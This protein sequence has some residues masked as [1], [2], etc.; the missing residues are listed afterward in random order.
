M[1][2]TIKHHKIGTEISGKEFNETYPDIELIKLTN[3]EEN[4]NGFQFKDGLNID[5][6]D[7]YPKQECS[8]GGIYFI[9]KQFAYRW[10]YY[11]TN[12]HY[13][14]IEEEN[15]MVYMRKVTIPDDARIYIEID[16][17]KAD[18]IILGS[19]TEISKDVYMKAVSHYCEA[20]RYIPKSIIP[21]ALIIHM[22]KFP[23][24]NHKI[25]I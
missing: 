13:T 1:N 9:E 5:T 23:F 7:F 16:K 17:F 3:A 6:I 10:T 11:T 2:S 14:I 21:E 8:P 22:H 15:I 18:K 24:H 20:I 25:T 12:T 4:H 19:R